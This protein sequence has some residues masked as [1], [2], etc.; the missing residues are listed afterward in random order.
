[1]ADLLWMLIC[2]VASG[3][4]TLLAFAYIGPIPALVMAG[5]GGWAM[6]QRDHNYQRIRKLNK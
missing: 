6:A 5:I 4:L 3:V 1:M 2:M